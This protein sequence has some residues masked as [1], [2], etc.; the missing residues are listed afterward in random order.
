MNTNID[1]K[2]SNI[3]RVTKESHID[4]ILMTNRNNICMIL[5]CF[6]EHDIK[7]F[8]KRMSKDFNECHFVI[9]C[10]DDPRSNKK[11]YNFDSDKKTYINE[12]KNV[13]ELPYVF[14]FYDTKLIGRIKTATGGVI[15]ETLNKFIK[16]NTPN[17]DESNNDPTTKLAREY[18]VEKMI[19]NKQLHELNE[20]EKLK[21]LKNKL[22]ENSD[23][24]NINKSKK[25]KK[26]KY[27]E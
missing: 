20:Y 27:V 2:I 5:F 21:K 12:I 8:M 25:K 11:E 9:V 10:I 17:V 26:N 1:T 14:F 15:I 18:Q 22:D 4:Q 23:E 24:E 7:T 3:Y 19:E 16:M 6:G 13:Q